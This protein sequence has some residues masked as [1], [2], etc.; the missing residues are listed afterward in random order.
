MNFSQG[1]LFK[2]PVGVNI[3]S[4]IRPGTILSVRVISESGKVEVF[5]DS[6][7][8]LHLQGEIFDK[9]MKVISINSGDK[10]RLPAKGMPGY[11]REKG[12]LPG[13]I[14]KVI[15]EYPGTGLVA[16]STKHGIKFSILADLLW[17]MPKMG[18]AVGKKAAL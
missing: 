17:E 15:D 1:D 10:F 18:K 9:L 5:S 14:V 3:G 2:V 13:A 8:V 16:V 12:L 11:L 4:E 6:H 7:E